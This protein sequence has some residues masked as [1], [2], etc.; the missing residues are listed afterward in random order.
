MASRTIESEVQQ[1]IECI[2]QGKNF[3]LTGGAGSGKTYSLTSLIEEIGDL[4][5]LKSIVCIT[6]TNNAVAEIRNRITNDKLRV[7]T[8]HEFIWSMISKY[9]KEM[10]ETIVEMIN[11]KNQKKFSRPKDFEDNHIMSTDYF[12]DSKIVYDEYYGLKSDKDSKISHDHILIL[13]ERMFEKY[14]KICDILKD[15]ANI[16]FVDE[17]QD[18]DPLVTKILLTHI[19]QSTKNNSIGFFGDSMQAIYDSG[20]GKIVDDELIY[21]NKSQ[22]RRNPKTVICLANKIRNDDIKQE[23][24]NDPKAPNMRDNKI[25]KGSIKFLYT[26]KIDIINNYRDLRYFND[27]DFT[28]GKKTKELWLVHKSNAKM[29]E[30]MNL[31]EL[32]NSDLIIELIDKIRKKVKDGSLEVSDK[33]FESIATEA[34]IVVRGRGELLGNI[35]KDFAYSE[36]FSWIKNKNW[37][38]VSEFRV[39][40]DSLLSYKFNGLIGGYEAKSQRD[41][42]LRQLDSIYEPIELYQKGKYNDFLKRIKRNVLSYDDKITIKDEMSELLDSTLT[43]GQVVD[44]A[45]TIFNTN[46]D[47]FEDFINNQ[48]S[49]LWTRLKKIPFS[50]YV[51]SIKYQKEHLPFATQHS[52]K[53][54]EFDNVLVVLDNGKWNKYN[55]EKMFKNFNTDDRIVDRTKKLFYVC[56]TRPKINL[57]V[58]M[59]SMDSAVIERA[60]ELFG[61]SNVHHI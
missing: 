61:D 47:Y 43:I 18:T 48:G 60:K 27:W 46:N 14:P 53:G 11:D 9:Q 57:I 32:Y 42:V 15:V 51:H 40:K 6:Y 31:F 25:I 7:S 58:L 45:K 2:K 37:E 38:E 59:P 17:Y 5:P 33:N 35:K 22:N 30:F 34:N 41:R 21:I 49:Y 36:A 50:E 19:K 44:K 26:E 54:S 20:V 13:A 8:I 16:I 3:I 24:S 29:A 12:S 56:C 55:F 39:N 52:I 23:P 4:Y 1:A 10:K 28:D